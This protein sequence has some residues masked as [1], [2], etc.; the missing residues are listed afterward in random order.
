MLFHSTD[1]SVS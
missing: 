1:Y